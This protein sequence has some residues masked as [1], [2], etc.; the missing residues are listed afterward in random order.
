MFSIIVKNSANHIPN[1]V[2]IAFFLPNQEAISDCNDHKSQT[3][4][5]IYNNLRVK[6]RQCVLKRKPIEP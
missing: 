5:K 1:S 6:G 3:T 4:K 2:M